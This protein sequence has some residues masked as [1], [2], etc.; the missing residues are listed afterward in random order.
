MFSGDLVQEPQWEGFSCLK[1]P[2]I[3]NRQELH[4]GCRKVK[5]NMMKY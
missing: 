1:S 4:F 5:K 2:G 3:F